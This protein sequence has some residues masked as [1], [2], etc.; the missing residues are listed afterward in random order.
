MPTFD[1]LWQRDWI[2]LIS[3]LLIIH[4]LS[5]DDDT[6]TEYGN[7][8]KAQTKNSQKKYYSVLLTPLPLINVGNIYA[9]NA[10]A[11]RTKKCDKKFLFGF[12]THPPSNQCW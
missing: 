9:S 1:S 3:I 12:L 4:Y 6:G 8:G 2:M 7:D 5:N 11:E 10:G